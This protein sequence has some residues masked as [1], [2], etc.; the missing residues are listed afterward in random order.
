M[1]K[2]SKKK[3]NDKTIRINNLDEINN[4]NKKSKKTKNF[5]EL[6]S[7]I[8]NKKNDKRIR[9]NKKKR[10]HI[11]KFQKSI[12]K[13]LTIIILIALIIFLIWQLIEC[14]KWQSIAKQMCTNTNSIVLDSN[15][16]TVASIG[17]ERLHKNVNSSSIPSNL[18]NAYVAI[19]D[20]RFYKHNGIDLKRTGGAI[21]SYI[22]HLGKGSFGGSTITQQ[23]VKNLTGNDANSITRKVTEWF[24]AV[25]LEACMNKDDILTSYLNIIYTGPNIYGVEMASEFY[26]S[27]EVSNLTLA[28]CA[29]LAGINNSPNYYNPFTDLDKSEIIKNRTKLVLD[30]M[31]EL[32]YINTDEF[33]DAL[34]QVDNGLKLK[35]GEIPSNESTIYSY[36]TD[37]LISKAISDIS[38]KK[39]IDVKFATNYLY[40]GGLK[41]YSTVDSSVQEKLEQEY[42]KKQY[43]V[44]SNNKLGETAQSA[45]VVMDHT[46]RIC[47]RT[48]SV[49]LVKKQNTEDLIVQAKANVKQV[50]V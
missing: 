16:N 49:V 39:R 14:F 22:I 17:N 48:S 24:K 1:G 19:E 6:D 12:L 38:S 23:L 36:H 42:E 11:S 43:M 45:M 8:K 7:S 4:L 13:F 27:K 41:L 2:H 25:E 20:E 10:K 37:A 28:E 32:K 29:F 35:K 5:D 30:K 44:P 46:S 50:L 15:E 47:C 40:M 3:T 33:N 26:F 34:S 31:L 21:F 9:K 18:K